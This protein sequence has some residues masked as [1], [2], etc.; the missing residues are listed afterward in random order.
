[1]S[2]PTQ[3]VFSDDILIR[4]IPPTSDSNV[5]IVKTNSG[6][7]RAVSGRMTVRNDEEALSCSLLRITSPTQLLGYLHH[8]NI[9]PTGWYVCAFRVRDVRSVG[10]EVEFTPIQGGDIGHC[11]IRNRGKGGPSFPSSKAKK[12]AERTIVLNM[13]EIQDPSRI[14]ALFNVSPKAEKQRRAAD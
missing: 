3:E 14:P 10:F 12:L 7:F 9:D 2:Q 11:G 1:M 5:S 6:R 8:E 13:D 4:R